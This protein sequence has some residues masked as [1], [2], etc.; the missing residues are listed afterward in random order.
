MEN[1]LYKIKRGYLVDLFAELNNELYSSWSSTD[2]LIEL[3]AMQEAA[4]Q[5]DFNF[6]TKEIRIYRTGSES[7][8]ARQQFRESNGQQVLK[9][10]QVKDL[11]EQEFLNKVEKN[12]SIN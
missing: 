10:V 12:D 9:I 8:P 4:M 5:K 1:I 7:D 6:L 3:A 2:V 11:F